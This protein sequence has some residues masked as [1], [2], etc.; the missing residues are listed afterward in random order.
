VHSC[1]LS[2]S[3]VAYQQPAQDGSM[4]GLSPYRH[5]LALAVAALLSHAVKPPALRHGHTSLAATRVVSGFPDHTSVVTL[6]VEMPSTVHFTGHGQKQN[7]EPIDECGCGPVEEDD[8]DVCS[9]ENAMK[10]LQCV[11]HGCSSGGCNCNNRTLVDACDELSDKCDNLQFTCSARK[12]SCDSHVEIEGLPPVKKTQNTSKNATKN[13]TAKMESDDNET[14]QKEPS[15]DEV[16]EELASLKED[17]CKLEF[18]MQ[19]GHNVDEK[20]QK[21]VLKEI[22]QKMEEL[23]KAGQKLPEMHCYKHFEEWHEPSQGNATKS[24]AQLL[25]PVAATARVAFVAAASFAVSW[26]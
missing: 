19:D 3:N 13:E 16:Y 26:S 10:V 25:A 1:N 24:G 6:S 22:S 9:C 20:L 23:E 21:R 8:D 18:A 15:Y 2:R 7:L 14:L 4:A 12:A 5:F 17:K 11:T